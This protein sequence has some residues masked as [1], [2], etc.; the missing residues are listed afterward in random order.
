M[1]NATA[2]N[3]GSERPNPLRKGLSPEGARLVRQR[4]RDAKRRA[5]LEKREA[6]REARRA[7]GGAS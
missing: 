4:E 1:G 5:K 2:R 7:E 6:R 3:I